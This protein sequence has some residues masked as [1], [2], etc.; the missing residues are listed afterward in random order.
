MGSRVSP[1]EERR[2]HLECYDTPSLD[3]ISLIMRACAPFLHF[4]EKQDKREKLRG[5]RGRGYV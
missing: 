1:V 4:F 5:E 2:K 3:L